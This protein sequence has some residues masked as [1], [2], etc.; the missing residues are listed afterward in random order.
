MES[1]CKK[2]LNYLRQG[3]SI[4]AREASQLFNCDRLSGR[5]YDLRRGKYGLPEIPIKTVMIQNG[6]KRYARYSLK[7]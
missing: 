5:I 3:K 1:Q 2:I 4:S 7:Y 6:R